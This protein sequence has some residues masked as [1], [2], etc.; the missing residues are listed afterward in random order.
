M[1]TLA[2]IEIEPLSK[3]AKRWL[4]SLIVIILIFL[5][6][7]VAKGLIKLLLRWWY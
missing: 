3:K 7:G 6:F 1:S 4:T 2:H 5:A